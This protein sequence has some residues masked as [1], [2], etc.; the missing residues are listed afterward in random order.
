VNLARFWG[1]SRRA[2]GP[3]ASDRKERAAATISRRAPEGPP[4][5]PSRGYRPNPCPERDGRFFRPQS[6]ATVLRPGQTVNGSPWGSRPIAQARRAEVRGP[7]RR[8]GSAKVE[9]GLNAFDPRA[10]TDVRVEFDNV[11]MPPLSP[12][13]ATFAGRKIASDGCGSTCATRSS[14]ASS[15]ERTR[16]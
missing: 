13:A 14:R 5:T 8:M 11:E 3:A 16:S 6:G 15:P 2:N 12:Y 4:A 1:G 7:H 10:F 9:G